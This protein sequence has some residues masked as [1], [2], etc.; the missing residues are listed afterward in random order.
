MEIDGVSSS[1]ETNYESWKGVE[2]D[3]PLLVFKPSVFSNKYATDED[4]VIEGFGGGGSS[5]ST[6]GGL[7]SHFNPSLLSS[8]FEY[9]PT[10]IIPIKTQ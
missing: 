1:Q 4:G 3:R 9:Y 6:A 5:S 7:M 8:F 2:T 10:Q